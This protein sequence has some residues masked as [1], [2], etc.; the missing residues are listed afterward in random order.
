MKS[1]F[2]KIKKTVSYS[3]LTFFTFPIIK[4]FEKSRVIKFR[5]V[6]ILFTVTMPL[7]LR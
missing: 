7:I 4:T 5:H 3:Y 1:F 2:L 6:Y